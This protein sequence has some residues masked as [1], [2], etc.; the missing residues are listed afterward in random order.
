MGSFRR[1]T[2]IREKFCA[3]KKMLVSLGQKVL[4]GT[5][6]SPLS[7][8]CVYAKILKIPRKAYGFHCRSRGLIGDKPAVCDQRRCLR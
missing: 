4:A 5:W 8:K 7:G 6:A 2:N 3:L 1:C